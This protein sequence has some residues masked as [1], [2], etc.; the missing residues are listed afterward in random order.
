MLD[1]E[2]HR[3]CDFLIIVL[4][5]VSASTRFKKMSTSQTKPAGSGCEMVNHVVVIRM[6]AILMMMIA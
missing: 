2:L 1:D 3:I 6:I 5:Q 4:M